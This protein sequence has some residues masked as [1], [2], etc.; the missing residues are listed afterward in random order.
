MAS[1][2]LGFMVLLVGL[3]FS[4]VLLVQAG[5]FA[6]DD[7]T[8]AHAQELDSIQETQNQ[9]LGLE[10]EFDDEAGGDNTMTVTIQNNGSESLD[11]HQSTLIFENTVIPLEES[12]ELD[13][14]EYSPEEVTINGD[15]F[16][17]S[18]SMIPPQGE[19]VAEFETDSDEPPEKI[20]FITNKGIIS[21]D[22]NLD[23]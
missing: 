3:V 6:L 11:V 16:L 1:S 12:T 4:A 18:R 13:G 9:D 14:E 19:L 8:D 10:S 23:D 22:S 2:G 20:R 21:I 5:V 7:I 17:E 15:E